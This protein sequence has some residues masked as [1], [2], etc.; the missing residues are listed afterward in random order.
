MKRFV[1]FVKYKNLIVR[2]L[3]RA[4]YSEEDADTIASIMIQNEKMGISTHG[5][6]HLVTYLKKF[7]AGSMNVHGEIE[8]VSEGP[9]WATIDA[10]NNSGFLSSHRAMKLAMEKAREYGMAYVMVKNSSHYGSGAPYELMAAQEGMAAIVCSN[11]WKLMAVPG[12]KEAVIGNSPIGFAFPTEKH[13]PMWLDIATSAASYTKILRCA[14]SGEDVPDGWIVDESGLPTN[15][16]APGYSLVPFGAHKG[17]GWAL[18]VE[19]IAAVASGGGVLGQVGQ[20]WITHIDRVPNVCH[21][22]IVIDYGKILGKGVFEARMDA[23]IDEIHDS[24]KA[25][26]ATRI[27][28][29][30]E[31]EADNFK[32]AEEIGIE[33][34]PV[35][36]ERLRESCRL[37]GLDFDAENIFLE[38]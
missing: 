12:S 38:A 6:F 13:P 22:F 5:T 35:H 8:V 9:T 4:G 25:V 2:I 21:A 33:L 18:F 11:T 14:E 31:I 19:S 26:N 29:P 17:Y 32:Q 20:D 36:I 23:C 28:V 24:P 7:Q 3:E 16:T 1:D 30:G 37:V 15:S 10:H 27:Y 34:M